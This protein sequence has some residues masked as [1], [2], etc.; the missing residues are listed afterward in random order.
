MFGGEETLLG[1]KLIGF[2]VA[3]SLVTRL[4]GGEVTGNQPT[5]PHGNVQP[6]S[7]GPLSSY[8]E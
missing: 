6:H 3:S 2:L 5:Y 7:Q 1:G 8:L 4:P